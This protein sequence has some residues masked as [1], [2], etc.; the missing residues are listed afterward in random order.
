MALCRTLALLGMLGLCAAASATGLPHYDWRLCPVRPRPSLPDYHDTLVHM[1]ADKAFLH[2]NGVSQLLGQVQISRGKQ[3]LR[4]NALSF[5]S[6]TQEATSAGPLSLLAPNMRLSAES[7]HFNLGSR[8]GEFND[9]RYHYYPAH[10]QGH[11]AR[12][13]RKNRSITT[14]LHATYSTCP[15]GHQAWVL[16]AS[17]VRLDQKTDQGV[18]RNVV[19]RFKNVPI[20]YAPYFSFPISNKRKSGLLPPTFGD[21]SN[22]GF[23]YRQPIYWNIAPQ[24]DA[25]ITPEILTRRGVG[26]GVEARYLSPHSYSVLNGNY[27]P[28]DRLYGKSRWLEA[29]HQQATPL[30]GLSTHINYNRVSDNAYFND[31]GNS[32]DVSST[33]ELEQSAA[34]TYSADYWNLTARAQ[35]YQVLDPTLSTSERPYE[36]LPQITF[37]GWLPEHPFGLQTTLTTDWTRFERRDSVTGSRLN[38]TPGLRLPMSG[39]SWFLTPAIKYRYIAYH[40]Q[41]QTAGTSPNPAIG[42]PIASL[43]AGLYFERTAGAHTLQTLEP[44]VYYLYAPYRNQQNLPVFDT[45]L[46]DFSFSQLF[47]D[48]RFSGGDRVGDANQLSLALTTRFINADTGARLFSASAGQIL[49][50]RPRKVTLPGNPVQTQHRS[51]YAARINASLA[52]HWNGSAN[53]TYNPYDHA[54]DTAYLS[55]QYHLHAQQLINVGYQYQRGETNQADISAIWP[56]GS[57]WQATG[58]W[59][60]SVR[61]GRVIDALAG[62]QYNS[63]CW[64]ARVL[65]RRYVTTTPGKYNTGIYFELVLKGL[66]NLGNPI[67]T[68]LQRTIPD[69]APFS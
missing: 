64:A 68:Y 54:V 24:A 19:L 3:T 42:L 39:P 2:Q 5:D 14:L 57:H 28:Y 56:L 32:L 7:G 69:Y 6:K 37:N 59:N 63:C 45:T 17:R 67:G 62:L 30:P 51:D 40:L 25:T 38:L 49:Y 29:F 34:A 10:A 27:L 36:R 1:L 4:S 8:S 44:R 11:A 52:K 21:S 47:S 53:L 58:R 60:F 55:A 12:I 16:S 15:I 43:D 20:L 23:E 66:G 18:A 46:N 22:S 13:E 9:A 33:T 50:F 35:K 41:N 65:A 61:D 48:N 31:I 26:L